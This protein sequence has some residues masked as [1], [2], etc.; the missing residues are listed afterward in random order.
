MAVGASAD[1]EV[2]QPARPSRRSWWADE[3]AEDLA[4]EL[5][6]PTPLVR[7]QHRQRLVEQL[8]ARARDRLR[9]PAARRRQRDRGDAAVAAG[10]AAGDACVREPIYQPHGARRGEAEHL[11]EEIDSRPVEEL[12]QGRERGAVALREPRR[13]GYRPPEPVRER[14]GKRAEQV[15]RL[16]LAR[17]RGPADV[18]RSCSQG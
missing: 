8:E 14:E 1:L 11:G 9:P 7:S 13:G 2:A 3:P 10:D 18:S 12:M 4:G 6:E 15:R 17:L 16:A 5:A